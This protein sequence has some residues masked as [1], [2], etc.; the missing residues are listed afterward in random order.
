MSLDIPN[1]RVLEK[2]GSGQGSTLYKAVS[3]TTS[4]TYTLKYVKVIT[5]EE[6]RLVEQMK[7]EHLCGSSLD[8]PVLRKTYELRYIRRR[9]RVKGAMLFMEYVDGVTL[10]EY[11]PR[12]GLPDLLRII[13]RVAE[14]LQAMHRGGFVHADLKPGNMLIIPSGDVKLIDFGQSSPINQAKARI[15]G[16]IDYMAPEQAAKQVLDARTDVFGLGATLHR[17]LTGRPVATEMNQRVD[18]HSLSRV[19]VRRSE[20]MPPSLEELPVALGKFITDC[21]AADPNQR[22]RDMAEFVDR[23]AM[24]RMI[25][26][27]R[28]ESEIRAAPDRAAG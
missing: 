8:H 10:T 4:Q 25:L 22:P 12:I 2:L 26:G 14:G 1:Y 19:G 23:S 28:T 7:D 20:N 9:L 17:V 6:M 24:V 3:V 16:T 11:A 27:K 18:V 15:Q 21:C 13:E 5:P